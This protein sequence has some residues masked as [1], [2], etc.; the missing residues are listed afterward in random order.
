MDSAIHHEEIAVRAPVW[1]RYCGN[2]G[3]SQ[4]QRLYV[5][6][7][8]EQK[9]QPGMQQE[10]RQAANTLLRDSIDRL[11]AQS[12]IL[13]RTADALGDEVASVILAARSGN[14]TEVEARAP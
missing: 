7:A 11:L 10:R 8:C 5:C 2:P 14:A 6:S 3:V 13:H 4:L 1:C 12:H 9:Q